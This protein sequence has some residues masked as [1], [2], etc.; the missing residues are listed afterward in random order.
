MDILASYKQI[1]THA[2]RS[3]QRRLMILSGSREW[4]LARLNSLASAIDSQNLLCLSDDQRLPFPVLGIKRFRQIL[5]REFHTVI[6]DGHERLHPD[7]LGAAAGT[8]CGGGVFMLLLPDLDEWV[9]TGD[10]LFSNA[11]GSASNRFIRRLVD[12]FSPT[13]Y[14]IYLYRQD[15]DSDATTL[16]ASEKTRIEID[17]DTHRQ[18]LITHQQGVVDEIQ[19]VV[20][21]HRRRPLVITADRGRGKSACLGMAAARLLAQRQEDILL[22]APHRA[23][24]DSLYKHAR[25][26]GVDESRLHFIPVDELCQK[27]SK[28]QLLIVDEAG[29]IPLPQLE[30]LTEHYSRIV[31][32]TTIHGYEGNGRGFALRFLHRLDQLCPGWTRS[33]LTIPARWAEDDPLEDWLN[34]AL[35]LDSD[36]STPA[37]PV[38]GVHFVE[39]ERDKLVGDEALLRNVFGLLVLA[40][41]QTRPYDLRLMLD[42]EGISVY[43][44]FEG[45]TLVAAAIGVREGG[46]PDSLALDIQQGK[47]RLQGEVLPQT[48]AQYLNQEN[49]LSLRC[50]RVMRIAVHPVLQ[51][52]GIGSRMLSF[53]QEC[54]ARE[55]LDALGVNFGV[56]EGLLRFWQTSGYRTLRLGV[57]KESSSGEYS[58]LMLRELKQQDF[59]QPYY[60]RF[61]QQLLAALSAH[62]RLLSPALVDTLLYTV[63][64]FPPKLGDED[65]RELIDFVYG[66]GGYESSLLSIHR[67]LESILLSKHHRLQLTD[68][69]RQFLIVTVLQ[70]CDIAVVEQQFDLQGKEA[71]L[72]RLR[73]TLAIVLDN[74]PTLQ[75]RISLYRND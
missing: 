14:S 52:Q 28:G 69:D 41:Y 32:S 48:L 56:R 54:A 51:G 47:R 3:F 8:L 23:A 64:V 30:Q 58:L 29:A 49:A 11:T 68:D 27:P 19:H 59:L 45:E 42:G 36:V 43:A 70:Q 44:G 62:F 18:R 15:A 2:Q 20:T 55:G 72:R 67:Q 63:D 50:L 66:R 34:T 9:S 16:L 53:I 71:M 40:H 37:T 73:Q 5:G 25:I 74:E 4:C 6:L 39:L 10:A 22:T 13:Q 1:S 65:M 12:T 60:D 33:E 17:A 26:E 75:S 57:Q 24:L 38:T 46:L 61:A 35:L 31:F 21:G 7:V